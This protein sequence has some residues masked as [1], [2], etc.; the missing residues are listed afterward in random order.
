MFASRSR[1]ALLSSG[2]H[3]AALSAFFVFHIPIAVARNKDVRRERVVFRKFGL[4]I[5]YGPQ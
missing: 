5:T 3:I 4:D 1:F 2:A